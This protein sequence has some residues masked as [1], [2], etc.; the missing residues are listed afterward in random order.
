MLWWKVGRFAL[1][2]C[3]YALFVEKGKIVIL[4][5]NVLLMHGI[6]PQSILKNKSSLPFMQNS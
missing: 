2:H 6:G 1:V 3:L 5:P 4:T